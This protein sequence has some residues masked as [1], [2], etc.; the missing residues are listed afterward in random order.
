MSLFPLAERLQVDTSRFW[1]NYRHSGN[2]LS[3]YWTVKKMGIPD[4]QILLFLADDM[5]CNPRNVFPGAVYNDEY[6]AL[7]LYGGDVQV[8]YRGY[9]VNVE[10]FLRVLSGRQEQDTPRSRRLLS[11]SRSNIMI[12][13]TGHG[14]NEFLKF[15]VSFRF[16]SLHFVSFCSCVIL[17]CVQDSEEVT[18]RDIADVFAQMHEKRRFNE[19]LFLVDSCQSTTMSSR[20]YTANVLGI[21]SSRI[22][23]NSYSHI[24]DRVIGLSMLDRLTFATLEFFKR[25]DAN[26]NATLEQLLSSYNPFELLSHPECRED[27]FPR[28]LSQVLL[29]DFF[30][31]FIQVKLVDHSL[32][33]RIESVE[34]S[35]I[36]SHRFAKLE[37]GQV[38]E[39]KPQKRIANEKQTMHAA[40]VLAAAFALVAAA[41]FA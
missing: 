22:A 11:D 3:I 17:T 33:V 20:F 13:M 6:H 15:Q 34:T 23:E 28:P 30:G 32:P 35:K 25:I 26:S 18:S 8:D 7:N 1:F 14:G 10:N 37:L 39:W 2:A 27:L 29:S 21:G 36:E 38:E 31:Q 41:S 24:T 4:S 19:L 9:E 16:I 5:A 40:A 12:Y